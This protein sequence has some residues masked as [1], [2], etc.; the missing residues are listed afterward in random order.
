MTTEEQREIRRRLE[1]ALR[2]RRL[3]DDQKRAYRVNEFCAAFGLGRTKT[4]D[5]IKAGKL[6]TVWVGGRRLIPRDAAEMLIA[7]PD[8]ES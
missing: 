8:D 1:E 2:R 6:R 4:Y 5:L 3:Q 7:E